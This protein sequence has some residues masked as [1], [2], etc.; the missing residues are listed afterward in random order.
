MLLVLG[1]NYYIHPGDFFDPSMHQDGNGVHSYILIFKLQ[2]FDLS[3]AIVF[4]KPRECSFIYA[5]ILVS[6]GLTFCLLCKVD[7]K[8]LFY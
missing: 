5:S 7:F 3:L 8:R 1:Y 4:S 6:A 2:W